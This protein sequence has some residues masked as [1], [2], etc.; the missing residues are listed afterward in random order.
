MS[1]STWKGRALNKWISSQTYQDNWD[2]IFGK[3]KKETTSDS[4]KQ[5]ESDKK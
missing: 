4:D 5:K 3:N 1:N 2:K